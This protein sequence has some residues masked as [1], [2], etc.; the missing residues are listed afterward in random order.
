MPKTAEKLNGLTVVWHWVPDW[1]SAYA[2]GFVNNAIAVCGVEMIVI[3]MHWHW[4]E[5]A[6]TALDPLGYWWYMLR[7]ELLTGEMY[8]VNSC[9]PTTK[10]TA[11][12]HASLL[13]KIVQCLWRSSV[14]LFHVSCLKIH[15]Y[16]IWY[17]DCGAD[18]VLWC[19]L[20]TRCA[21]LEAVVD[22]DMLSGAVMCSLLTECVVCL[23]SGARVLGRFTQYALHH[24]LWY[25]M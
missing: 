25:V 10:H 4:G 16:G 5:R 17:V 18:C 24:G 22:N 8:L 11:L 19:H 3:C 9:L 13:V 21:V 7:Y 12:W 2:D 15:L 23:S 6:C 20:V 14:S 1:R